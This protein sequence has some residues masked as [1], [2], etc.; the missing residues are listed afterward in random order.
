MP[1]NTTS[2]FGRPVSRRLVLLGGASGAAALATSALGVP[3]RAA[4]GGGARR[5]T[6]VREQFTLGI[7]SGDPLPDGVVL[8][9]RLAPD[10]L[11]GGGMPDRPVPVQWQVA[12]DERFATVVREGSVLAVPESAH[13]VHVE[14]AGLQPAREYFYRFRAGSEVSPIGRT[15]T[16]PPAGAAL[17]GLAFAFVSCQNY[18]AGYYTAYQNMVAEDLDLVLHLGDYIY[19]GPAQ[20]GLGRGHLPAVEVRSLAEYRTRHAQYKTD[21]D[22]QA[23]HAAFPWLVTW[24]DHEVEN[25]YADEESDPDSPPAEFLARRAAA[26]QAHYEHMPLRRSSM[27]TGPDMLLHRRIRYGDLVE[28]NVLD[29][30]QYRS[31]QPAPCPPEQRDPSG[32]C[33]EALDPGR[34]IL[35]A[36]QRDWFLGGLASST[37]RWKVLAQQ[38]PLAPIDQDPDPD[39]REFGGDKWD[40]YVADRQRILDLIAERRVAKPGGDHRRRAHQ[41]G[42]QRPTELHRLRRPAAGHRVHRYVHLLR[43][44]PADHHQLRRRPEQP[45]HTLPG[46]PPRLRALHP[47]PRLVAHRLPRGRRRADPQFTGV[48]AR[49]LRRGNRPGRRPAS[50]TR[51]AVR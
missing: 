4:P 40:G 41:P 46:Q 2:A 1:E 22:L 26:Y 8:W 16:A 39:A 33:P 15:R 51:P 30:R 24:D 13:S 6:P 5:Q 7:A 3:G 17:G 37:A 10:P 14:V 29:T 42:P 49:H 11:S 19:E 45:A 32:Y 20:G 38:V 18:P 35:G 44:R 28:F 23:A 12:T 48:D 47:G 36:E 27:P 50:L 34:T 43:R 9:T 31:D 21:P 25:N